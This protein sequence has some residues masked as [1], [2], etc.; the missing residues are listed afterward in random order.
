MLTAGSFKGDTQELEN[1]VA[2][3][4]E[5]VEHSMY[6]FTL[7]STRPRQG[8]KHKRSFT[9]KTQGSVHKMTHQSAIHRAKDRD[10]LPRAGALF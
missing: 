6:P 7:R 5:E 10:F 3:L 9:A 1:R 8:S 2:D 4:Q